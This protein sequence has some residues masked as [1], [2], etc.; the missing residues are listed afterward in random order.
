MAHA[1]TIVM[2]TKYGSL[3]DGSLKEEQNATRLAWRYNLS[4]LKIE[5]RCRELSFDDAVDFIYNVL[6]LRREQTIKEKDGIKMGAVID[7]IN[8]PKPEKATVGMTIKIDDFSCGMVEN[9]LAN[10]GSK[11]AQMIIFSGDKCYYAPSSVARAV[12]EAAEQGD[13]MGVKAEL[14]GKTLEVTEYYSNR[15]R[16]ML[17][18]GRIID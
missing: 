16:R 2:L 9:T 14:I 5:K 18:T 3:D 4:I 13:I 7:R 17:T 1:E 12:V 6:K 15:W 10:D 8:A 11:R